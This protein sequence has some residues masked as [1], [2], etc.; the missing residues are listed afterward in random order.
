MPFPAH[1][2]LFDVNF[3]IGNESV[4]VQLHQDEGTPFPPAPGYFL[5]LDGTN[6][7]LLDGENLAL[8]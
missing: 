5:L 7:L 8:L 4:Y 3:N 1:N 2:F 6:F